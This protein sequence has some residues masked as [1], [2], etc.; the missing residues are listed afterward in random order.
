MICLPFLYDE[1]DDVDISIIISPSKFEEKWTY[2]ISSSPNLIIVSIFEFIKFIIWYKNNI[3]M[4]LENIFYFIKNDFEFIYI[5]L[6]YLYKYK[7]I[8][9]YLNNNN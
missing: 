1:S 3:L 6:L 8:Y 9:L 5:I 7:Y 2:L 4:I